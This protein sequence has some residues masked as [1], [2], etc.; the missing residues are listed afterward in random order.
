MRELLGGRS[1]VI[2]SDGSL[3]RDYLYIE[4]G[5]SA[6]LHLAEALM[7]RP[8]LVG[9]AFNFSMQQ[10]ITVL[11]MFTHIRAAVGSDLEP[12][13]LNQASNEIHSQ[14]LD[15]GAARAELG[16]RPAVGLEEG[17]RRT[18]DWYRQMLKDRR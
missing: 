3:V 12:T 5:V 15:S 8:E 1:P 18:A 13:V 6:Y 7:A 16:W 17:L 14:H 4:D 9:R 2:R 11:D 10:P